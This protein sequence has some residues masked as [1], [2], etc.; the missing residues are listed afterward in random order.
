V[1]GELQ[2]GCGW[3]VTPLDV[4]TIEVKA[5]EEELDHKEEVLA[6]LRERCGRPW[7]PG[8]DIGPYLAGKDRILSQ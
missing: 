7:W 4:A 2:L 8:Q 5:L 3:R 1:S 6:L